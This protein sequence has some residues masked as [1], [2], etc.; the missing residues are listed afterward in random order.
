MSRVARYR[1]P[2]ADSGRTSAGRAWFAV[3]AVVAW[4]A[5]AMAYVVKASVAQPVTPTP[6]LLGSDAGQ[7]TLSALIDTT[8]YFT[9]LSN[10][11]VAV[12]MTM[13]WRDPGRRG[14]WMGALRLDALAMITVTGLVY[15]LVLAPQASYTGWN[16]ASDVLLHYVVPP[17]TVLVWLVAGPRGLLRF[18]QLGPMLVVP[19]AWLVY[20][21]VRGQVIDA[22]PYSFLD[23]ITKGWGTVLLNLTGIVVAS[24]ALAAGFVAV[25]RLLSRRTAAGPSDPAATASSRPA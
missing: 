14:R 16:Q 3:N 2:V 19:V 10:V 24:L 7:S 20:T 15:A 18:D 23:V 4:V 22:Y 5:V 17:L 25:D 11:V 12:V 21:L 6:S 8:S 13:L 9:I 1:H